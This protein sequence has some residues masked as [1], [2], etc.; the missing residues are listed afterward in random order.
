MFS[1]QADS[2][3]GSGGYDPN[4]NDDENYDNY[5]DETSGDHGSGENSKSQKDFYF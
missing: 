3:N 4:L 2:L 1:D 5:D